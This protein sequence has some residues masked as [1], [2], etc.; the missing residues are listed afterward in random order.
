MHHEPFAT[1]DVCDGTIWDED[2]CLSGIDGL[3]HAEEIF[4][5]VDCRNEF[6]SSRRRDFCDLCDW[7]VVMTLDVDLNS[8]YGTDFDTGNHI[9]CEKEYAEHKRLAEARKRGG[10]WV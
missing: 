4:I 7:L 1:C 3:N 6:R 9:Q 2:E 5:H 10:I 8:C